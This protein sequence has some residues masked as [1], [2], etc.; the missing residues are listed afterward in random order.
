M[1]R[2]LREPLLHF[3]GAGLVLSAVF[4]VVE[5]DVPGPVGTIR[6]SAAEVQQLRARWVRNTGSP[7]GPAE[8]RALIRTYVKE[9][10]LF[11]EALRL[12]LGRND[13][14]VRGRLIRNMRFL[15]PDTTASDAELVAKARALGM[16][17][18]DPVVRRRLIQLMRFRIRSDAHVSAEAVRAY[19]N[20][21]RQE[22]GLAARYSFQHLFFS[23]GTRHNPGRAA[24]K[25]LARLQAADGQPPAKMGDWFQ[26]G[27]HFRGLSFAGIKQRFGVKFAKRVTEAPVGVWVGP[28]PTVYGAH[29][30]RVTAVTP[31]RPA[32]RK[33]LRARAVYEL[34][35]RQERELM[36]KALDRL[37]A[38]YRVILPD[39]LVAKASGK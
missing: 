29:L 26:L 37:R 9:Q 5:T 19:I 21:H 3:L 11:H 17:R 27:D 14:V 12:G 16:I 36:Q 34:I 35:A 23:G 15:H 13:P 30:V 22:Y 18:Q 20:N 8:R 10:L 31:R 28:V 6:V 25:A 39:R 7:P 32:D 33:W 4:A 38:R 2:L 24:Q 1:K